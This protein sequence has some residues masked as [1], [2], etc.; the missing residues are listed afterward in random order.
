MLSAKLFS[1]DTS[2]A[3]EVYLEFVDTTLNIYHEQTLIYSTNLDD[4]DI[5][6]RLANTPRILKFKNG[7][8]VHTLENDRIDEILKEKKNKKFSTHKLESSYKLAIFSLVMIVLT[9]VFF[10][11][12]GSTITAKY[13]SKVVPHR[14]EE[15]I[16][17]QSLKYMDKYILEKSSL[18]KEKK[19]QIQKVFDKITNNDKNYH[20]HFRKGLGE[21]A[22]ALPSG[23]IVILDELV[24]FSKGD[25]DMIFGVLAHEKGH[26]VYKHSTQLI[27]KGS[28][29]SALVTYFTG[30]FSSLG[31]TVGASL[32]NA[33]YSREFEQQADNY[34]KALMIKNNI[35]PKHLADFF[36]K[37]EEKYKNLDD[38]NFFSSHPSS[39][40]RIKNLLN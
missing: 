19:A 11:T 6:S 30:D 22:F 9:S 5:S 16:S 18:S 38:D 29:V 8:I 1:E 10:L 3:K 25:M 35:S 39:K 13:L 4:I 12:I 26:V 37:M 15:V 21:N 31:A 2:Q 24:K 7:Y 27:I 33:K 36:I 40:D 23:D 17:T 14:F 32:V 28:I 20:L 34:A